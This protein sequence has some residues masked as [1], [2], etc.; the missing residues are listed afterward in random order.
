[1]TD[2]IWKP[3]V[4]LHH[5][6]CDD[7]F[8]SA[9]S[10][11]KKWGDDV[12][13]IGIN[14]GAPLPDLTDKHVLFVDYALPKKQMQDLLDQVKTIVVLDHH[15]TAEAELSAFA[16]DKAFDHT[17]IY[18]FALEKYG[19]VDTP[20]IF[21][22]FDMD[23]SGARM[24]WEFCFPEEQ[25]P[26]F[27]LYIEDQDL[28]RLKYEYGPCFSLALRS[29]PYEFEQWNVLSVQVKQLIQE[30]KVIKRFYDKKVSDICSL[31][32]SQMFAGHNVLVANAPG[33]MASDV[34]HAL[35]EKDS[36]IAFAVCWY[37]ADGQRYYSLRSD[38]S[39]Q[40]VSEVAKQLGG[41]GHRNASG[42]R[43]PVTFPDLT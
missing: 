33:F 25:P 22:L 43:R 30:G 41:G 36:D 24:A 1:M 27:I 7:G 4:C 38:D 13:Y 31:A 34:A 9:W 29:Y 19:S 21:C 2:L 28:W 16:S 20:F 18:Q 14:H 17:N 3:D 32:S 40:D 26:E 8:G 23:K 39:R 6:P 35:L 15:K 37:E 12:E 5:F 10:V 11:W 42:F